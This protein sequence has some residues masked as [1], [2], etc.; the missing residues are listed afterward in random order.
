M[1]EGRR[2]H[3]D[4][5]DLR[6]QICAPGRSA[7]GAERADPVFQ[8]SNGGEMNDHV[9]PGDDVRARIARSTGATWCTVQSR[10]RLFEHVIRIVRSEEREAPQGTALLWP[11]PAAASAA[12][13]AYGAARNDARRMRKSVA[14]VA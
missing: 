4:E 6:S 9:R 14:G 13:D 3:E 2:S 1:T 12:K 10:S 7:G 5:G 8:P 11:V